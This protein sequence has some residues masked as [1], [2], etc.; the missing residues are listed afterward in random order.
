[1][2]LQRGEGES[3]R[4]TG[5]SCHLAS[6][7]VDKGLRGDLKKFSR[8]F[9]PRLGTAG[10]GSDPGEQN[11]RRSPVYVEDY[12]S[13][14]RPEMARRS[15][16]AVSTCQRARLRHPGGFS[17]PAAAAKSHGAIIWPAVQR[18]GPKKVF[19]VGPRASASCR[20]LAVAKTDDARPGQIGRR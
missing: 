11:R 20:T 13:P 2:L 4:L 14:D 3:V 12:A 17:E 6:N 18:G 19:K 5:S 7:L 10:T 16:E 8:I 1:M 15:S 9:A